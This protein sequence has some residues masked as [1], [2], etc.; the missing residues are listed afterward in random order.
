MYLHRYISLCTNHV[1]HDFG[2]LEVLSY[3]FVN[4][5]FLIVSDLYNIW[6]SILVKSQ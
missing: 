4:I 6:L 2:V 1:F 5:M 3:N